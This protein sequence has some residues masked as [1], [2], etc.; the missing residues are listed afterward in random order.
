LLTTHQGRIRRFILSLVPNYN[1]ADDI[2]QEVSKT[3]WTKFGDFQIG[4][5]FLSW[6]FKIAYYRIL[7]YRR[8]K[9]EGTFLDNQVIED[10]YRDTNQRS[11]KKDQMI[12]YLNRCISKLPLN[13]QEVLKLK[14][15][16][17]LSIKD[18]SLRIGTSI[19]VLYKQ[20]AKIHDWLLMCVKHSIVTEE[21]S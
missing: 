7:E 18:V 9:K 11:N 21:M 2:M 15:E 10:I 4:T 8:S 5:D 12:E 16:D 6:A 1:D 14:Y 19:Y 3:M 13:D 20:M 17:N